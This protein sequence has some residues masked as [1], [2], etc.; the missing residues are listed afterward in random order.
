LGTR[1]RQRRPS[2]RRPRRRTERRRLRRTPSP[3][4]QGA[5]EV[6]TRAEADEEP[7]LPPLRLWLAPAIQTP[8]SARRDSQ[9]RGL[10]ADL[11]DPRMRRQDLRTADR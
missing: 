5:A 3:T 9:R 4:G 1:R 11:A 7:S 2:R 6:Q 10:R 8:R